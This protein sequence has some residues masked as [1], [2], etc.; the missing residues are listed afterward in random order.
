MSQEPYKPG[1]VFQAVGSYWRVRLK[2]EKVMDTDYHVSPKNMAP[3]FS[4]N[5]NVGGYK[6]SRHRG[7]FHHVH[8]I[9]VLIY[10]MIKSKE[11]KCD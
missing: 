8:E 1:Q 11:N 6:Y 4:P 10:E 5:S 9:D 2:N 7:R 3:D